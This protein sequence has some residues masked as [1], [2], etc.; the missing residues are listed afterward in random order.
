MTKIL[1]IEKAVELAKKLRGQR[2]RIVLVGG[3][4]DIL[5]IGHVVFLEEAKKQ[6]DCLLI[7]LE[8][9]ESVTKKK[10][11]NRPLQ[12]QEDRAKIL[13]SLSS[14]DHVVMLPPLKTD[15]DYDNLVTSIKPAIIASTSMDPQRIHKK[16]QAK[17]IHAR[18]VDVVDRIQNVSSSRLA[19]LLSGKL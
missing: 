5:H 11:V 15:G 10:G 4:F 14:V 18:L 9:D 6:G 17:R 1:T 3:C 16:R 12:S 2:K 13:S 7:L 19:K 8:S